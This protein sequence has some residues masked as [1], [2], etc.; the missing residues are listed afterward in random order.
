MAVLSPEVR[1]LLPE[2]SVAFLDGV[3]QTTERF[4]ADFRLNPKPDM[5]PEAI[6]AYC[7]GFTEAACLYS[8]VLVSRGM[9]P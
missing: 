9:K 1:A 2:S 8:A 7:A 4:C 6:D 3:A 5:S